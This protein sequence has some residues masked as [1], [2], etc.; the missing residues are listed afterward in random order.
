MTTLN[1]PLL[2]NRSISSKPIR[3][4]EIEELALQARLNAGGTV[5]DESEMT[6]RYRNVLIAT[7]S[8]AADLEVMTLPMQHN[9]LF[10]S[11]SIDE[12][13]ALASA[14]QD[15]MGHAHVMF[16]LLEDFGIDTQELIFERAPENF[17]TFYNL[18]WEPV[19]AISTAIG[20]IMGDLAGY[21]TTL[22]LEQNCSY[23]PYARS[24][25]KVN[26]EENFHVKR[27]EYSVRWFMSLGP[28]IRKRVQKQI[29]DTFPRTAEWFGTTDD[30]KSRTDQ[31]H[32]R[33]RG[34][35]NDQLR[36]QW[37]ARVV[38]FCE[39]VGLKVPAHFDEQR[40]I[41][42]LDYQLPILYDEKLEKWDFQTVTWKEKIAQWKRGGPF[43]IP[44]LTRL[45]QELWGNSLW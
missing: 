35:S 39:E 34:H 9:A 21:I 12:R 3:N 31:L 27:G 4:T 26:F 14:L 36:Q 41:Y 8:I 38:P 17:K 13:I 10:K 5:E 15:E 44:A 29:D 22:D 2:N 6:E 19:D 40:G 11:N 24:L 42:V 18:E 43:K 30:V 33:V 16:R 7:I 32:Y 28:E 45:Q 37:L 23:G 25:R 20:H 1:A